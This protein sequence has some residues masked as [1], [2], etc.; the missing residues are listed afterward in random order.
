[1]LRSWKSFATLFLFCW[2]NLQFTLL[3]QSLLAHEGGHGVVGP[4]PLPVV[5]LHLGLGHLLVVVRAAH[6]VVP[7][8]PL[9]SRQYLIGLEVN[10]IFS[11]KSTNI[12]LFLALGDQGLGTS[13][14]VLY[15]TVS[16]KVGVDYT[17]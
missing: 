11:Y 16:V 2:C 14:K 4:L 12:Y 15:S 7:P 8:L 5:G 13:P 9:V 10:F 3:L 6:R 1:M 17:K